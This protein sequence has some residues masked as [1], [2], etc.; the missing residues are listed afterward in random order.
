MET[1]H[2]VIETNPA[3]EDVEFLDNRI[4]EFNLRTTQIPF[5]GLLSI[6]VRDDAGAIIAGIHG[7]TWG[8][9]CEIRLLWVREDMRGRDYGSGLLQAAERE[10][11]ARGCR[12]VV[13]D[14]HSFQAPNFYQRYGYEVV[15]VVDDYPRGHQKMYLRKRLGV[16]ARQG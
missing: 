3:P 2:F 12:Q 11:T 6:F 14:T 5:G 7:W 4:N 10:A 15:G 13:L 16:A 8:D 1:N 9:T